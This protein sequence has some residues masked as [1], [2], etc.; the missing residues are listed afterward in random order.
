MTLVISGRP[1]TYAAGL[2]AACAPERS[3]ACCGSNNKTIE[4]RSASKS[5]LI[6][7]LGDETME[8]FHS[9]KL[10]EGRFKVDACN[11]KYVESCE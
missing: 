3:A 7:F 11:D 4:K 10:C 9:S 2:A 6:S 8:F 1:V 5:V